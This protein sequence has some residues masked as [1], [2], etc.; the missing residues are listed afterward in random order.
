MYLTIV[1]DLCGQKLPNRTSG[2]LLFICHGVNLYYFAPQ[3]GML[4]VAIFRMTG[5]SLKVICLLCHYSYT[6]YF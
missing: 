5:E 6:S 3:H 4:H 2:F 1:S